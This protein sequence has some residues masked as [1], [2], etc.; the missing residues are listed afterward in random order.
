MTFKWKDYRAEGKDRYKAMTLA[1]EK[2]IRNYSLIANAGR[3]D[4]LAR[5][6]ELLAREEDEMPLEMAEHAADSGAGDNP[7]ASDPTPFICPD[8]GGPPLVVDIFARGQRP[9][10]PPSIRQA[11]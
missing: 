5:A 10:A 7:R 2:S 11:S 1:G 6:R 4:H 9:R 3:R 8:C